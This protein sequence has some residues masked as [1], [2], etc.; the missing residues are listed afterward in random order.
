MAFGQA[1]LPAMIALVYMC[2]PENNEQLLGL[3]V[4][5]VL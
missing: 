3:F 4:P 5:Y 2:Q 1:A